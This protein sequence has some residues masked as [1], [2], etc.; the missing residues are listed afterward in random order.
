MFSSL[1]LILTLNSLHLHYLILA[2]QTL[3]YH[4]HIYNLFISINHLEGVID[5]RSNLFGFLIMFQTLWIVPSLPPSNPYLVQPT[6][7]PLYLTYLVKPTHLHT[8]I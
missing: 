5:R 1:L 3:F 6:H 8:L 2:I 7:Y 4:L